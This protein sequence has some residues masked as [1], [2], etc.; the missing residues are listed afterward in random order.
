M[1]CTST[2]IASTAPVRTASSWWSMLPAGGTPLRMRDSFA[3]Q[4]MPATLMPAAPD[5]LGQCDHLGLARRVDDH[6]REQRLVTVDE[7]VDAV[8]G[9]HAKVRRGADGL[10]RA[11][12][13]VLQVGGEHRAAP[14]AGECALHR[15][16]EQRLVVLVGTGGGA[17]HRLDYL[18]VDAARHHAEFAPQVLA[19]LGC[20]GDEDELPGLLPV[21][22]E[23]ALGDLERQLVHVLAR[24][25][26]T[27]VAGDLGQLDRVG[28]GSALDLTLGDREK[29][30][31][32]IAAV[33]GVRGGSRSDLAQEVARG[34]R[35]AGRSAHAAV[36]LADQAAGSHRAQLAA[37]AGRAGRARLDLARAGERRLDVLAPRRS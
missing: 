26:D 18:A 16:V 8:F 30:E 12:Q 15:A 21:L 29:R 20:S 13:D 25:V 10:W 5:L 1:H 2:T 28:D 32:G 36:V 17:V 7:D 22:R 33:I 4:Q 34:D 23:R 35:L 6:R 11:V 37:P 3:V 14:A 19:L 27:H 9:Q 24:G 31:G